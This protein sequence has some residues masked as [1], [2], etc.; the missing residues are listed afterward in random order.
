MKGTMA[1]QILARRCGREVTPGEA[2]RVPVDVVCLTDGTPLGFLA[3]GVHR[4]WD[5]TRVIMTFDHLDRVR[6]PALHQGKRAFLDAQG[7]PPENFFGIGRHGISHQ[8]PA[9][10]GWALP[11]A[12]FAGG[13]TQAATM[14]AMN[15]LALATNESTHNTLATGDVWLIV[16]ECVSVRLE[17]EL[18][19]GFVAKDV[20]EH[21]Q[22]VLAGVAEGTIVEFGGPAVE[23]LSIDTRLGIANVANNIG[24]L[25]MLFPPDRV[26]LDHVR[27]RAKY[28]YEPVHPRPDAG[29]AAEVVVDLGEVRRQV[30]GPDDGAPPRPVEELDGLEVTAAYVGSCS[31]ARIA[32][33]E[34]VARIVRGRTVHPGVRFV[35][36]PISS[37]VAAEAAR[38]GYLETMLTAG[39]TVT[40]PGCGAC[41]AGNQSPLLLEPGDRCVTTSVENNRGRMGSPEADIYITD[42]AVVAASALAGRVTDPEP[43]LEDRAHAVA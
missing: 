17:G 29:Y 14:G 27:D 13:D 43:Y 42:P 7:I 10:H 8:I 25:S 39:V 9:E 40:T 23:H 21:L 11:G 22:Q 41:F 32:D 35:V 1:G 28:A 12:V 34:L 37:L 16:P 19:P 26:L 2:V 3:D 15:A 33:L 24:A 4:V 6:M 5:P 30:R 36:T 38:R 18:A 20:T 31:S